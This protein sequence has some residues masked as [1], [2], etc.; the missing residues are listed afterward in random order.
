MADKLITF[1]EQDKMQIEA[2]VIDKDKDGAL[3]YLAALLDRLKGHSGHA[4]GSKPA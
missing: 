3:R 1:S 4:C 2:L